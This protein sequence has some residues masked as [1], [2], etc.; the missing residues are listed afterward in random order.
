MSRGR[1]N[2]DLLLMARQNNKSRVKNDACP[3]LRVRQY[4]M[5]RIKKM[6]QTC[7]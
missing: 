2:E 1:N 7:C 5:S 6:T 4:K 3:L